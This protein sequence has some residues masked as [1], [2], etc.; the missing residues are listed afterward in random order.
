MQQLL[1]EGRIED[2]KDQAHAL[3]GNASDI[4]AKAVAAACERIQR[5]SLDELAAGVG[6]RE[7][8]Q[9]QVL[10]ERTRPAL[11]GYARKLADHSLH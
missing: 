7:L 4:G 3:K 6:E 11:L 10:L 5:A 2:F 8:E 1:A 9:V